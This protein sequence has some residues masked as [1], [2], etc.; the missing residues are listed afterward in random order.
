M[1]PCPWPSR[2][3]RR[4]RQSVSTVAEGTQNVRTRYALLNRSH[5]LV[6]SL[7]RSLSDLVL[8]VHVARENFQLSFG[9]SYG[10]PAAGAAA[11]PLQLSCF[12]TQSFLSGEFAAAPYKGG[13]KEGR[14]ERGLVPSP[15]ARA[16]SS[17]PFPDTCSRSFDRRLPFS[18]VT[19]KSLLST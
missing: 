18:R 4:H 6:R 1:G 15:S 13:R 16:R 12:T 8:L 3:R 9:V 19:V 10:S 14:E 7:A 11:A 2:R 17:P 5:L